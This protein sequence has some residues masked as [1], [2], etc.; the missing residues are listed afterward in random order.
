[1][2]IAYYTFYTLSQI[3]RYEIRNVNPTIANFVKSVLTHFTPKMK[4]SH[5]IKY[6]FDL[7]EQNISI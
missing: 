7:I 2:M 3:L 1:M 6:A 4:K 5:I